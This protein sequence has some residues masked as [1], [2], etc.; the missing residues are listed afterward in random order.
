[1]SPTRHRMT[2]I[3]F[4]THVDHGPRPWDL[5]MGAG[6]QRV[7]CL[8]G[9]VPPRVLFTSTQEAGEVSLS[10]H[11]ALVV[12][13]TQLT[14][15]IPKNSGMDHHPAVSITQRDA[16]ST[17][18]VWLSVATGSTPLGVICH[19]APPCTSA[20]VAVALTTEPRLAIRLRAIRA[21]TPYI[22]DTWVQSL[23]D[24]N[25]LSKYPIIPDG[26]RFGFHAGLSNLPHSYTTHNSPSIEEHNDIFN[27][28]INK[29]ISKGC[30]IG[31]LVV[32]PSNP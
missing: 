19:T 12:L 30:Y 24:V 9:L 3:V 29:E 21:H 8:Q 5:H 18:R 28:I 17:Q 15:A 26:L 32:I 7:S 2:N 1:M 16:S 13:H 25:L 6:G 22:P 14:V 10:V 31:P 20:Q 11:N 4:A 27:E 23:T